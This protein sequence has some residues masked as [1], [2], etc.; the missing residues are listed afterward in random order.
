MQHSMQRRQLL[1]L[2]VP[3]SLAAAGL[4]AG[5]LMLKKSACDLLDLGALRQYLKPFADVQLAKELAKKAAMTP[6]P[7]TYS[8]HFAGWCEQDFEQTYRKRLASDFA[9]GKVQNVDGW[10]LSETEALTHL[11]VYGPAS[12]S[13]EPPGAGSTP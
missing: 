1:K 6:A 8:Q 3:L 12:L 2:L 9:E 11:L 4:S 13:G 7:A 10:L 5:V